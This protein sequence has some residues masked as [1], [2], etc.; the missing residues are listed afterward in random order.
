MTLDGERLTSGDAARLTDAEGV[1]AVSETASE[2]LLW[3]MR[4]A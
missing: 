1:V 2:L 3:E 4:R